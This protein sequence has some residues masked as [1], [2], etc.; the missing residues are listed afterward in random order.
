[1]P[2]DAAQGH[3]ARLSPRRN[4][5]TLHHDGD[6]PR[7]R[8]VRRARV[9]RHDRIARREAKFV[10]RRR[11][12]AVQPRRRSARDADGQ[13]LQGDP[14]HDCE[15][16][17]AWVK[18]TAPHGMRFLCCAGW[19]EAD[20]RGSVRIKSDCAESGC[21]PFVRRHFVRVP[22]RR[23][24]QVWYFYDFHNKNSTLMEEN[25]RTC[26]RARFLNRVLKDTFQYTSNRLAFWHGHGKS[27]DRPRSR[28]L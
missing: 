27:R 12:H 26:T 28:N 24:C 6:G 7:S 16:R 11:L 20:S 1:F 17:S 22:V 19:D 14:L 23:A 2:S 13:W 9:A 18:P 8:S 25:R 21:N 15:E 5:F 3:A 10:A 4:S